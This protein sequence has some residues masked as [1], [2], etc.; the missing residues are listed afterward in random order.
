[1]ARGLNVV[2]HIPDESGFFFEQSVAFQ[3]V[4]NQLALVHDS[5]VGG[6]KKILHP[7][8][9]KLPREGNGIHRGQHEHP[10]PAPAGPLQF[11]ARVRQHGDEA[12]RTIE[13]RAEMRLQFIQ[14]HTRQDF[15]VKLAVGEAETAAEAF[16]VVRGD[17]V[18]FEH[19]VGRFDHRPHVVHQGAGP[20]EYQ[21]LEHSAIPG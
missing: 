15:L 20:V 11:L 21:I 18:F 14:R 2:S 1:M 19:H 12:K 10:Q 6:L 5:R 16:A 7:E 13:G 3:D 17:A 8:L 9:L 4:R